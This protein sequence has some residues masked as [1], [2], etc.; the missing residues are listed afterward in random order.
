MADI[1]PNKVTPF[2]MCTCSKCG[3]PWRDPE[4]P[5]VRP[6]DP[7][8]AFMQGGSWMT[9]C[10]ECGNKRCPGAVN[11]RFPCSH[12]NDPA[13]NA[14]FWKTIYPDMGP[15]DHNTIIWYDSD[16][17]RHENGTGVVLPDGG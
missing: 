14:E 16:G 7:F 12:S 5:W 17:N 8:E 1:N 15:T 11:H 13:V 4:V 3:P 9:L 10:P 6:A 2:D